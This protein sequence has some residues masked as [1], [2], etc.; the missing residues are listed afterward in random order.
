MVAARTVRYMSEEV[1]I[2]VGELYSNLHKQYKEGVGDVYEERARQNFEEFVHNFNQEIE[3]QQ[4]QQEQA[5]EEDDMAQPEW[6]V[7][8]Q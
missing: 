7:E 3:R 8:E 2:T 5:I 6:E 4:E 1:T